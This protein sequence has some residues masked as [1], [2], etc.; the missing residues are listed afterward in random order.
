MV[1]LPKV[2]IVTKG[3]IKKNPHPTKCDPILIAFLF[4]YEQKYFFCRLL[5]NFIGVGW[6]FVGVWGTKWLS[7]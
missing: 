5:W 7:P 2:G 3:S 6:G 1:Y 4:I